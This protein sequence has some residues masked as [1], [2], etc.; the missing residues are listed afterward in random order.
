LWLMQEIIELQT[1]P[2][3]ASSSR[4]LFS[5]FVEVPA[6]IGAKPA[7]VRVKLHFPK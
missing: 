6:R 5:F 4:K 7:K 3:F 2:K 1:F